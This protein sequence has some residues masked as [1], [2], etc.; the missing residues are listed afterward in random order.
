MPNMVNKVQ[1][2]YTGN[3]YNDG[4]GELIGY[5]GYAS[6][7]KRRSD[8]NKR[9]APEPVE[10]TNAYKTPKSDGDEEDQYEMAQEEFDDTPTG[11]MNTEERRLTTEE[12]KQ[13]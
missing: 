3:P 8:K 1:S 9:E 6:D 12:R 2:E 7:S 13:D 10:K 4:Q 5:D 11:T